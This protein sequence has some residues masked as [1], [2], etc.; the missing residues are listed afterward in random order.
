YRVYA[1]E[2]TVRTSHLDGTHGFFN[3]ATL[4]L[5]N[6]ALRGAQHRVSLSLPP[7]WRPFC[8]LD[9]DG[10]DFVAS[11]Y[12]ELVDS[13]FE[14]GPH[15]PLQF[16]ASG[17]PHQIVVWGQLPVTPSRMTGDLQKICE[18]EEKLF[19]KLPMRRY[20]FLLYLTDKGRGGLEHK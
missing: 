19:G 5:Y 7:H 1:N 13:P 4:F 3:G 10:D 9:R 14:L 18:T 11:D 8:S 16:T 12:D 15:E 17:V 20:L 6:E 2:L